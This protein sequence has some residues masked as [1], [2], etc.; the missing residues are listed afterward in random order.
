MEIKIG[1]NIEDNIKDNR[2][3]SIEY[4]IKDNTEL[5]IENNNEINKNIILTNVNNLNNI[6][7]IIENMDKLHHIE[8][9][10]ILNDQKDIYINENNN[11]TFVNLS[12][13]NINTIL[14]LENYINYFK[15]QQKHL[16]NLEDKKKHIENCYFN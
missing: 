5:D 1:S 11:G 8:I 13:L 9:L 14:K 15:Q 4:N 6:K 2:E 10:K 3:L 12:E 16:I 7:T